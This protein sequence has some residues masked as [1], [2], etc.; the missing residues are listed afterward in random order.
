MAQRHL[1][2]RPPPETWGRFDF[3]PTPPNDTKGRGCGPS[4]LDSLPGDW[5]AAAEREVGPFDDHPES[6]L[7]LPNAG[8]QFSV[9]LGDS[10]PGR[11][12]SNDVGTGH[13]YPRICAK[14]RQRRRLCAKVPFFSTAAAATFLSARRKK[15]GGRIP[16]PQSGAISRPRP[17]AGPLLAPCFQNLHHLLR[18]EPPCQGS[19]L[20]RVPGGPHLHQ[21]GPSGG[22]LVVPGIP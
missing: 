1:P 12:L 11:R 8:K 6:K 21:Q 15:S 13:D 4:P 14:R 9:P 22:V 7:I 3:A 18:Q 20:G 19:F 16:A 10:A 5:A 2:L 17:W